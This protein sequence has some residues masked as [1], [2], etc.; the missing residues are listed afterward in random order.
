LLHINVENWLNK[1]V[2]KIKNRD[3]EEDQVEEDQ[4]PKKW[5]TDLEERVNAAL[6]DGKGPSHEDAIEILRL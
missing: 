1:L 6:I 3:P 2:E 4:P 5:L